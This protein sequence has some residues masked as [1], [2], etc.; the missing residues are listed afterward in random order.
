M[1]NALHKLTR[2][3]FIFSIDPEL[4]EGRRTLQPSL[5]LSGGSGASHTAVLP[6]CPSLSPSLQVCRLS[7]GPGLHACSLRT[8]GEFLDC[9]ASCRGRMRVAAWQDGC[10]DWMSSCGR[11]PGIWQDLKPWWA[12]RCT[13]S[14]RLAVR[15]GK[16]LSLKASG[17]VAW[18]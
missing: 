5:L 6:L 18:V 13:A 1:C 15:L 4:G 11:G 2:C 3:F 14:E 10:E 9:G 16:G 12:N 8:V 17:G 7:R